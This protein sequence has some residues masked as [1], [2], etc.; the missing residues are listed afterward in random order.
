MSRTSLLSSRRVSRT[1][2]AA[3]FPAALLFLAG[4]GGSGGGGTAAMN[5]DPP[6]GPPAGSIS[7]PQLKSAAVVSTHGLFALIGGL[8]LSSDLP[9]QDLASSA[10]P[11]I[12]PL[13]HFSLPR[14]R[15]LAPQTVPTPSTINFNPGINLY[16]STLRASSTI[17][18]FNFFSDA[19]GTVPSGNA[20]ATLPATF[21][22]Y[23]NTTSVHIN[24]TSGYFPG[25]GDATVVRPNATDMSVT[26]TLALTL[27]KASTQFTVAVAKDATGRDN[28]SGTFLVDLG[29]NAKVHLSN[30]TVDSTGSNFGA[31]IAFDT[32][33][34]EIYTG[35]LSGTNTGVTI[36]LVSGSK[37]FDTSAIF[38]DG[39][40]NDL[41]HPTLHL[42][43]PDKTT[44]DISDVL[45]TPAQ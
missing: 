28:Y 41:P 43:F 17:Y 4:C 7:N 24:L 21:S 2:A 26:G 15:L 22:V 31:S 44:Q 39:N 45:V 16:Y 10:R 18:Q 1:L 29:N 40:G 23:P 13:R 30:L 8:F 5:P 12:Q 25:T 11:A 38:S 27:D 42:V 9:S 32:G 35:T 20:V 6:L 34:T 33:G 14:L 19:S 37:I 36:H 3:A